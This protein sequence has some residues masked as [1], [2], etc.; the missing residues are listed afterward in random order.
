MAVININE[1]M[2]R[3][4]ELERD[5]ALFSDAV[6]GDLW[7]DSIRFEVCYCLYD[8]LTGATYSQAL[9]PGGRS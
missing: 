8:C 9:R 5:F 3:F 2:G 1:F 6:D 4:H 7:W